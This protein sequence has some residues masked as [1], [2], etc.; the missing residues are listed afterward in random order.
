MNTLSDRQP[1]AGVDLT[2]GHNAVTVT[3]MKQLREA[4]RD[5]HAVVERAMPA[6]D[7][8]LAL[9]SYAQLVG[10]FYGFY[11]VLEPRLADAIAAH[12]ADLAIAQR[13]KVPLLVR[14]LAAL[15]RSPAQIAALPR[16]D[17]VPELKSPS[18]AL[19]VLYV[20]E[21]QTLGGQVISRHLDAQLGIG[22]TSGAAFFGGY[23]PA[24]G[25]MW[26]RFGGHVDGAAD[27]DIQA[28]VEAAVATFDTLTRWLRVAR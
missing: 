4:T 22:L 2:A 19:G 5:A 8:G 20:L 13:A 11:V 7:S 26:R 1:R 17:Q 28:A 16:C 12:G 6:F 9:T 15:G 25:E 27:L 18:H 3:P 14:D 24:T 23:G 10:A 21:G